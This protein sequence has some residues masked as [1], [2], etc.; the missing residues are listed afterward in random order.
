MKTISYWIIKSFKESLNKPALGVELTWEGIIRAYKNNNTSFV[1]ENEIYLLL[2]ISTLFFGMKGFNL[3]KEI[4]FQSFLILRQN[5]FIFA[6]LFGGSVIFSFLISLY[7]YKFLLFLKK[8]TILLAHAC[9][10]SKKWR[11]EEIKKVWADFLI[12]SGHQTQSQLLTEWERLG[13]IKFCKKHFRTT[14]ANFISYYTDRAYFKTLG[15]LDVDFLHYSLII[16]KLNELTVDSIRKILIQP[17][18]CSYLSRPWTELLFRDYSP[19]QIERIFTNHQGK[20][21]LDDLVALKA[22]SLAVY[23]S[24][25]ELFMKEMPKDLPEYLPRDNQEIEGFS[26]RVLKSRAEYDEASDLFS[27][28]VRDYF[29]EEGYFVIILREQMPYACV[30]FTEKRILEIKGYNN[31]CCKDPKTILKIIKSNYLL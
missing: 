13:P 22:R 19:Q 27:N 26:C 11:E 1:Y 24:F 21:F 17:V 5:E 9:L 25:S 31:E 16:P 12:D 2:P 23:A 7:A 20:E 8:E 6:A 18:K 4:L 28:C 29:N 14:N 15:T 30:H 10:P 3:V